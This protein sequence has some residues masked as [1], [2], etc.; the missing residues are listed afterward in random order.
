METTVVFEEKISL[1]PKDLN[2]VA[3]ASIDQIIL[4]KLREKLEGKCSSSGWVIPGT[5]KLISRSMCQGMPG[6]FTG[7]MISWVQL[8]GT[9]IFPTDGNVVTGTVTKKNK[10]GLFVDYKNA[11]QIIVPRDLHLGDM[12]FDAIRI[13]DE[14]TV[15]IKKSKYQI[16]DAYILSVG[17]MKG[18]GEEPEPEP[19]TNPEVEVEEP[20]VEEPEVEVE[21]EEEPEVE[22]EEPEPEVEEEEG[23]LNLE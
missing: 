12:R 15:E 13:G 17:V 9:V 10:M 8:E 21:E 1:G 5:L 19:E 20:E 22:E 16:N 18:E 7:A 11:M 14:V 2:K 3:N 4:N 23:Q 6:Q